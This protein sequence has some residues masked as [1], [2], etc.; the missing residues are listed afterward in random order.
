MQNNTIADEGIQ[1]KLQPQ[2]LMVYPGGEQAAFEP[3]AMPP[4][5]HSLLMHCGLAG[6]R[7]LE[8]TG[9]CM[10]MLLTLDIRTREWS[11]SVPP[12]RCQPDAACWTFRPGVLHKDLRLAGSFQ[13]RAR[14]LDIAPSLPPHDG[15]HLIQHHLGQAY[16][17]RFF[18]RAGGQYAQT[19][20][21]QVI[22]D[23]VEWMLKDAR[24]LLRVE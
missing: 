6:V 23:D 12:Q 8:R 4:V 9:R 14:D 17:L 5:R 22:V 7:F 19:H 10:A 18:L 2:G 21:N 20:G 15:L 3:F 13:I 1:L 11:I 16:A 24:E